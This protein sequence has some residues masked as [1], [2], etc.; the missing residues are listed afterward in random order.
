MFGKRFNFNELERF[1][2]K[3][4]SKIMCLKGDKKVYM[5]IFEYI[6]IFICSF[7]C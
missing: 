5:Y 1:F 3:G 2:K 6:F 7:I 4:V